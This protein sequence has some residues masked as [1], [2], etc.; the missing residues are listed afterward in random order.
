MGMDMGYSTATKRRREDD[1]LGEAPVQKKST[2]SQKV[3]DFDQ[4]TAAAAE[5]QRRCDQ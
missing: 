5:G 1:D 4:D 3:L 2:M